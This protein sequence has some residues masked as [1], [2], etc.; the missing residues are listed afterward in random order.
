ME[1]NEYISG[2]IDWSNAEARSIYENQN[3]NY[4]AGKLKTKDEII[5]ILNRLVDE[6]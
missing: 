2:I 3:G 4:F 6:N 1:K 5:S